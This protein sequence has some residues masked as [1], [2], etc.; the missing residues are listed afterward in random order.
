ML[1]TFKKQILKFKAN[2][3]NANF[4]TQFCL[5]RISNGLRNPESRE[6][7]LNGNTYDVNKYNSI[8]KS[9]IWNNRKYLMIKKDIK[10][11]SALLNK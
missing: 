1:I 2:H 8:D 4:E 10:Q 5:G 3:K 9:D 6:V 11:C 7:P